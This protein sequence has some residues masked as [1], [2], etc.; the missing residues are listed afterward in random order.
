M[1][2]GYSLGIGAGGAGAEAPPPANLTAP[3]LS[4]TPD[5][6][7]ALTA[8]P[9]ALDGADTVTGRWRR[10][11]AAI[12]GA[13]GT[14]YL[15]AAEDDLAEISYHETATNAAGAAV[16]ASPPVLA[17]YEAPTAT[18]GVFDEIFD[19]H[20]GPQLIDISV[21]FTGGGL[22]YSATGTGVSIDPATGVLSVDTTDPI[23]D[24]A[25]TVVAANSGGS[26]QKQFL[27][28]VEGEDAADQVLNFTGNGGLTQ[29]IANF[30]GGALDANGFWL[31]GYAFFDGSNW[32]HD[33]LL[34]VGS[35]TIGFKQVAVRTNG[36]YAR[37]DA[38]VGTDDLGTPLAPGWK[39]CVMHLALATPDRVDMRYWRNG[40]YVEALDIAFKTDLTAFDQIGIGHRAN[41]TLLRDPLNAPGCGFA[42][43]YGDPAGMQA[44]A[45]N[46]GVLRDLAE[47]DFAG[48]AAASLEGYWAGNRVGDGGAFDPQDI[49][50]EA[51]PLSNWGLI[52]SVGWADR[53]PP[54]LAGGAAGVQSVTIDDAARNQAVVVAQNSLGDFLPA[55]A[56]AFAETDFDFWT[57]RGFGPI[58]VQSASA[59]VAG[60]LATV[61][62]TLNRDVHA[63]E[64][65][66]YRTATGWF[67]DGVNGGAVEEGVAVNNSTLADPATPT[68]L[69][70]GRIAVGFDAA[71]TAG[72]YE[73]AHTGG[74]VVDPGGGVQVV[75]TYPSAALQPHA[76]LGDVDLHG[77]MKNPRYAIRNH[78]YDGRDQSSTPGVRYV[79]AQND[80]LNLPVSLDA[81][82]S[83]VKARSNLNHRSENGGTSFHPV[84]LERMWGVHVVSSAPAANDFCPPLV[85]Y[86]GTAARPVMN[87]DVSAIASA[88]P[89][90]GTTG[91]EKP[92]IAE[93]A[94]R[95]SRANF[96][97]G[98]IRAEEERRHLTPSG[99]TY[100]DGY[101]LKYAQTLN[102]A[103]LS[104]I[105][106]DSAAAKEAVVRGLAAWGW[107]WFNTMTVESH[108]SAGN[109]GQNQYRPYPMILALAW[110]GASAAEIAAVATDFPSCF[111]DQTF[112]LT[113]AQVDAVMQPHGVADTLPSPNVGAPYATLRRTITNIIGN[114][115]YMAN[116]PLE[117]MGKGATNPKTN[118]R[119]M[120]LREESVGDPTSRINFVD[121]D[122]R[123]YTVDDASGFT[124]GNEVYVI[125][126]YDPQVG[127][128]EW[129][130]LNPATG[131]NANGL[132][133]CSVATYRNL[134][135]WSGMV[136]SIRALG[137]MHADFANWEGYVARAN[138]D[139]DPA[140]DDYPTHHSTYRGA[141]PEGPE[142][143]RW[144][145][146]FW[147]DHWPAISQVPSTI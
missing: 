64:V 72:F 37:G 52:G 26:A 141:D 122:N 21:E 114:D 38:G 117:A 39:L 111:F 32:D 84:Y 25:V 107:Q 74:Y 90:Y 5:I 110:S 94:D 140:G 1:K 51:G 138:Q 57:E 86:D 33:T 16:A 88:L 29:P 137:L 118:Y 22:T 35:S 108:T 65:I 23:S 34:G 80:A 115:V 104:L 128:Y 103:G 130:I 30:S 60:D 58:R 49:L 82:D 61:T 116:A 120:R 87:L 71:Y 75:D 55:P 83:F 97:A 42:W 106:D 92:P 46:G 68:G 31:A 18:G 109:A 112:R 7:Q 56:I 81:H 147:A 102:A 136:M 119:E 59:V 4:G 63:S 144:D 125:P 124:I 129:C 43:G 69:S 91:H 48:D 66:R 76:T 89:S 105:G 101:G 6:G 15:L 19:Q 100:E 93:V 27:L 53:L 13:T 54:W 143:Y 17:R 99:I 77:A 121:D 47:Y 36:G 134:L 127:D 73:D 11:G 70:Y 10:D 113:Q 95:L 8:V 135:Q 145:R 40:D 50:D 45:Y 9:G 146:D 98:Q 67:S 20:T 139:D 2:I 133:F 126:S 41:T 96:I 132:N 14:S 28:T 3:G 142:I 12:P 123:F 24:E 44:W 85:G 131:A 79:Q 78:G 62:L